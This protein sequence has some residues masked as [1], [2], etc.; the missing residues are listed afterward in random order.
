LIEMANSNQLDRRE[1]LKA[2][3]GT[4]G[5]VTAYSHIL[6]H[7][8]VQAQTTTRPLVYQIPD[9]VEPIEAKSIDGVIKILNMESP[10][11]LVATADNEA[12]PSLVKLLQYNYHSLT[13]KT[14]IEHMRERYKNDKYI[15]RNPT[16]IRLEKDLKVNGRFVHSDGIGEPN[17][18]EIDASS[19][20]VKFLNTLAHE[21]IHAV[22]GPGEARAYAHAHRDISHMTA[23]FPQLLLENDGKSPLTNLMNYYANAMEL[24]E[25]GGKIR[26]QGLSRGIVE[27]LLL[28]PPAILDRWHKI[29]GYTYLDKVVEFT[30]NP[31][32]D[33]EIKAGSF[34]KK[35][36]FQHSKDD[37][38][39]ARLIVKSFADATEQYILTKTPNFPED[40]K[41]LLKAKM[42][43]IK[44]KFD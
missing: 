13:G 16:I 10:M 42:V 7:N 8:E 12:V 22:Y 40:K 6:H 18:A 23:L 9:S 37:T 21:L 34:W 44:R 24:V 39:F 28:L 30:I 36:L 41:Q 17:Y 20:P 19:T 32:E 26:L 43:K 4:V 27:Y 5:L 11:Y 15:R 38:E 2:S 25:S 33:S 14:Y 31:S 29:K 35:Y 3:L 1:F